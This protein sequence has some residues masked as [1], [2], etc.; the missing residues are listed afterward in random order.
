ML[1]T[2]LWKKQ[3]GEYFCLSTKSITGKWKDH[4]IKR[5]KW[6]D[7]ENL[8][9][10][11]RDKDLYMCPHGFSEPKRLKTSSVD[12]CLL[13]SDMDECDPHT[14]PIKPT[15]AIES[16]PGRYVGY[17]VT[18]KP[19]S[20]ELNRRLAYMLKADLS[21]WDRTQVLRVPGTRNY[22]YASKPRV[23]VLWKDGP[24]YTIE[25]LE[26]LV[27][28]LSSAKTDQE[29]DEDAANVYKR[30]EKIIP[31][32]LRREIT[33]G[34]PKV[35]K[36]SEV[37][38]K[39]QNDLLELG[40]SRE[41]VF[42]LIWSSPWNKF[43]AER[44]WAE[45]DKALDQHFKKYTA[46]EIDEDTK[47]K[48]LAKPISETEI[49]NI[50]WVIPGFIANREMTIVE[51]D[52]GLGKSYFMQ[53]VAGLLCDGKQIPCFP[54]YEVMG[55]T[56]AYFDTENTASTVTKS[57]LT[58][59][60]IENQNKYFQEEHQFSLDQE[61]KWEQVVDRLEALRPRLV[62]FDTINTYIG[63]TDTYRS[64]ETQQAMGR[65]KEIAT[66]FNCSV[67]VLRHL[68]KGGSDKAIYRGQGSIAF[69]GAARVVATV[70]TLPDDED[71]RVVSCTKNNISA[72]FP[73]F[74]FSIRGLPNK[75][76]R[77]N[78]SRLEWG[79]VVDLTS[80]QIMS[81]PKNDDQAT[82]KAKAADWL[83]E[84]LRD[85][86]IESG[87]LF[88]MGEARGFTQSAIKRA[89]DKVGIQKD[90]VGRGNGKRSFWSL[91]DAGE[92]QK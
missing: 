70:S 26:K 12:P 71:L 47:W 36:R 67:V 69:A 61:E 72:F 40:L 25:K 80:D 90:Q 14:V 44:L 18:D 48:P 17:W 53:M 15:I 73:S 65:F 33:Q 77:T 66:R 74:T 45:L 31:R 4:F 55:G 76:G 30:Y 86:Q 84:T 24:T 9:A 35:G 27:P 51:G 8:I 58:D 2:K 59:N 88:R 13:Y 46:K 20:E 64:S 21:G 6:V 43:S 34:N 54:A 68:T 7:A 11:N 49:E 50:D 75:N 56:V 37:L 10:N 16:S 28:Q 91:L 81:A 79:D 29:L 78:R 89:A 41:E 32:K 82:S 23:K 92:A 63:S 19:A 5:G 39:M 57:R 1:A 3:K 62:V 52:P 38:W 42:T 60:R 22:K 87:K 83:R 85:G